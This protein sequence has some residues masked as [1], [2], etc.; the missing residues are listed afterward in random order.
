[1]TVA[2]IARPPTEKLSVGELV[3]LSVLLIPVSVAATRSMPLGAPEPMFTVTSCTSV[4]DWPASGV[5]CWEA[6]LAATCTWKLPTNPAG[7]VTVTRPVLL[8]LT[9]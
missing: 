8:T 1:L 6:A 9:V 5:L 2:P 4:M 7:G 3:M